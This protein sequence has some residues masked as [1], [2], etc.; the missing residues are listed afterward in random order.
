MLTGAGASAESGIP[1]FRGKGGLWEGAR[2]EELATPEAFQRDPEKVWRWYCWRRE[3]ISKA[4][5]NEAHR[6][7]AKMEEEFDLWVITQNVDGLHQRAGSRKVVELHGNIWRLKCASCGRTWEDE[8]ACKEIPPRCPSCGGLAR[9]DV[10]WFGEALPEEAVRKSFELAGWAEVFV[11]V[12]T[13]GLV[14][15]AAQLPFIAKSFGAEVYVVNPR[16]TPHVRIADLFIQDKASSGLR[17]VYYE[18]Q[19]KG[20]S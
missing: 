13:S 18:L 1:T 12:G 19:N 10:V 15:P 4:E 14:Q 5:P 16:P 2:P 9:P 17:R 3:L 6:L 7:L 20:S 8:Q 11:V